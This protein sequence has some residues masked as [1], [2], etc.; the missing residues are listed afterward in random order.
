VSSIFGRINVSVARIAL[1]LVQA[2]TEGKI[3]MWI[4]LKPTPREQKDKN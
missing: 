3:L 2:A 4:I 1:Y